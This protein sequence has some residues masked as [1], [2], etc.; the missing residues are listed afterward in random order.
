MKRERPS[1]IACGDWL[2]TGQLGRPPSYVKALMH[3][4][5]LRL[6]DGTA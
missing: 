5:K 1:S 3:N 4:G 2:S 6:G